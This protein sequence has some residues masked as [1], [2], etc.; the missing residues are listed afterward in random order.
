MKSAGS[1]SPKS[2]TADLLLFARKTSF[3]TTLASWLTV[4]WAVQL[5]ITQCRWWSYLPSQ[6]M[7]TLLNDSYSS[8]YI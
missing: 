2:R 1:A 8:P 4:A 3:H 7:H 5:P 6:T